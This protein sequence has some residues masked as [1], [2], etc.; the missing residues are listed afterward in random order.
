[1]NNNVVLYHGGCPDGM[2]AAWAI[3]KKNP[4][5]KF[6]AVYHADPPPNGLEG[7]DVIIVDFCYDREVLL[8]LKKITHSLIVL[9]HHITA[10]EQCGDLDF[11]L[12]DQSRSG[13]GLAWDFFHKED[14]PWLVNY[15]EYRDLGG[16]VNTKVEDYPYENMEEVL[17]YVDSFPRT[18]EN[19]DLFAAMGDTQ[20]SWDIMVREGVAILRYKNSL[21]RLIL[22]HKEVIEFEGIKTLSV[23][24]PILQSEVA[25][26]L[27]EEG[28]IGLCWYVQKDKT[29]FSLRSKPGGKNV[30]D[31]A[32]SFKIGGGHENASGFSIDKICV[33]TAIKKAREE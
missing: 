14:R 10:E 16:I 17:A 3:W 19:L 27:A 28:E 1:M 31:M 9:D 12:F 18:F 24:T 20:E 6:I 30:A 29:K 33:Q 8:E 4:E 21:V 22:K 13:A 11:C 26:E 25:N 23:N 2:T 5:A 7:K 15:I 32:K